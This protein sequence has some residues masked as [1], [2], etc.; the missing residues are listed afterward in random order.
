MKKYIPY[1]TFLVGILIFTLGAALTIKAD[2]GIGGW[3]AISVGLNSIFGI[4]IGFWLIIASLLALIIAA[5]LKKEFIKVTS[6]I[7]AALVGGCVDF[8]V[9]LTKNIKLDTLVKQYVLF[10]IGIIIVGVGVAI[11]LLPKL[12]ANP[13]DHLMVTIK[14][15]YN[16]KV[17]HAKLF[18]DSSCI[19][20]AL[21]FR[22][23]IGI[24]TILATLI[25][26]PAVNFFQDRIIGYYEKIICEEEDGMNIMEIEKHEEDIRE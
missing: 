2:I 17:M 8:W 6:F 9:E 11:Y 13:I 4:S 21:I 10:F 7:T 25:L 3:D 14:E 22:G 12:P 26:G 23:P 5:I 15:K 19:I 18:V 24:G 16:L 20:V 1:I